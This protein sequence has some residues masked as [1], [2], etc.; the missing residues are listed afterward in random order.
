MG[1]KIKLSIEEILNRVGLIL[2]SDDISPFCDNSHLQEEFEEAVQDND[3]KRG[4]HILIMADEEDTRNNIANDDR[5]INKERFI[6][7]LIYNYKRQLEVLDEKIEKIKQKGIDKVSEEDFKIINERNTYMKNLQ[8]AL[9]IG[10]GIEAAF[11]IPYYDAETK[12]YGFKVIDSVTEIDGKK[13]KDDK[14]KRKKIEKID[15]ELKE[16]GFYGIENVLQVILLTDFYSLMPSKKFGICLRE[17]IITDGFI[18]QKLVDSDKLFEVGNINITEYL[19]AYDKFNFEEALPYIKEDLKEY[20]EYIDLDRLLLIALYRLEDGL[21]RRLIRADSQTGVELL[22]ETIYKNIPKD[23]SFSY[24]LE[25]PMEEDGYLKEIE[26]SASDAEE[27]LKRF[28]INGKYLSKEE[29]QKYREDLLAGRISLYDVRSNR[30][31][32]STYYSNSKGTGRIS[33]FKW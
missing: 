4:K 8:E 5:R 19:K 20:I 1:K 33:W 24:L 16:L 32:C 11:P 9:S 7:L 22:M 10:K 15:E 21:E 30:R 31:Y 29:I 25:D 28:T 14:Y 6:L 2:T 13:V 12:K 23:L 3:Y 18:R 26:Y 27:C 17:K